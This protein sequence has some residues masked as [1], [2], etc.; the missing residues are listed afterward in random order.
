MEM[1]QLVREVE[2]IAWCR[3]TDHGGNPGVSSGV[4]RVQFVDK[5]VVMPW[6]GTAKWIV[7]SV[8]EEKSECVMDHLHCVI[9]GPPVGISARVLGAR[10][11]SLH[12]YDSSKMEHRWAVRAIC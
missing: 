5:V 8:E 6:T 2:Q 3:A 7:W 4:P 11:R 12:S 10:R 9:E 1:I